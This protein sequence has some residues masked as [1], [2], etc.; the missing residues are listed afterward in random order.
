MGGSAVVAA[1]NLTSETVTF[2]L[3]FT[4]FYKIAAIHQ[5]IGA[6]D[7]FDAYI[8]SL[9][10]IYFKKSATGSNTFTIS[11]ITIGA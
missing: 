1:G 9:T 5:A 7:T 6:P 11:F 3:A 8:G 4:K 10:S 2:P